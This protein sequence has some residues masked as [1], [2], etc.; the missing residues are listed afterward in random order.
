MTPA[1][2]PLPKITAPGTLPAFLAVLSSQIGYREGA[3]NDNVFGVKYGMNH[4]PWCGMYVS[5]S[6]RLAGIP[7]SVIPNYAYTPAGAD[8]FRSRGLW[9]KTPKVGAIVFYYNA[10]LGRIAHTGVVEKVH[11]DGSWTALEGNT[12][13]TGSRTGNGVYRLKRTTTRG[14]G[15]GYPKYAAAPKPPVPVGPPNPSPVFPPVVIVHADVLAQSHAT[16][17]YPGPVGS[18]LVLLG[19]TPDVAGY[20]ALQRKL[21]WTDAVD[22][23]GHAGM[24]SLAW[25]AKR[26]A[27]TL[28][29]S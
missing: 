6:A 11:S 19:L 3:S 24:T 20:A 2:K 10:S 23:D 25:L 18:A 12:S 7:T 1:I 22:L 14:G 16:G 29:E 21:G 8:W 26:F 15:F 27:L 5:I 9:G 28:K 4:E 17:T 13:D